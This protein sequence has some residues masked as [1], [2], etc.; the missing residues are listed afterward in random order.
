MRER[1]YAQHP[2]CH[3]C[4]AKLSPTPPTRKER[5]EPNIKN[6]PPAKDS[7]CL[8]SGEKGKVRFLS[9]VQCANDRAPL[10]WNPN[11][12][13]AKR[14]WKSLKNNLCYA[15]WAIRGLIMYFFK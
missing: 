7:A 13:G 8:Y 11:N 12:I 4:G 3:F 2:Y 9:C 14:H 10:D 5:V 15:G 6:P 1:L